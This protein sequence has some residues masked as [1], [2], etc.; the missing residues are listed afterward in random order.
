MVRIAYLTPI[1]IGNQKG[2]GLAVNLSPKDQLHPVGLA[3]I[4]AA[5]V[6]LDAPLGFGP[7]HCVSR[8]QA[9]AQ[10]TLKT[11]CGWLVQY[12]VRLSDQPS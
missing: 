11:S 2:P 10:Q 12:A 4:D 9:C 5:R 6:A 7:N 1:A 3:Q 8:D